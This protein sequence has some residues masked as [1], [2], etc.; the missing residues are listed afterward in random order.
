MGGHKLSARNRNEVPVMRKGIV[1][2][3]LLLW[4]GM[5]A[6]AELNI[7]INVTFFPQ[8]AIV[9]GYPVYYAPNLD[10]NYFYYEDAYW[11]YQDDRWY[12]S[13]WYDG[14]WQLI[15]PEFV[16]LYVLRIPV[17]YYRRPPQYF[18]GWQASEPP[19]WGEHWGNR[20]SLRRNGWNHWDRRAAPA[21][22]PLPVYQ[23]QYSGARYPAASQQR[24]LQSRNSNNH[25]RPTAAPAKPPQVREDQKPNHRKPNQ[26]KEPRDTGD[27]RDQ[28][29]E[30]PHP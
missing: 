30:R 25:D 8:L 22:A 12:S 7:G 6:I 16:P 5:P 26:R 27:K 4:A 17:R 15:D 2:L 13:S 28:R 11:V 9:P 29:G 19:R 14:P 23:R 18:R 24:A 20:W 1:L 10:S 21:P 3:G